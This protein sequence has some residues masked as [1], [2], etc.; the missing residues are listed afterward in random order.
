MN[1]QV[2]SALSI[3]ELIKKVMYVFWYDY[4][5]PN[6]KEKTKLSSMDTDSFIKYNKGEDIYA[7]VANMSKENLILQ[8]MK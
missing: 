4:V 8:V 7:D 1:K 3:L 2:Y 5:K 6:C